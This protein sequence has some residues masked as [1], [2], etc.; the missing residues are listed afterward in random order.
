MLA[1]KYNEMRGL[2]FLNSLTKTYF[3][4]AYMNYIF[5]TANKEIQWIL[6][7]KLVIL[8]LC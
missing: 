3:R 6:R 5:D 1:E 4:N 8:F 7:L 2:R